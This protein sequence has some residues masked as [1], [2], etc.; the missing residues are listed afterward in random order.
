MIQKILLFSQPS[1]WLFL[2]SWFQRTEWQWQQDR[3]L[4]WRMSQ[5]LK[6]NQNYFFK[7]LWILPQSDKQSRSSS[8]MNE[9]PEQS[10]WHQS[11]PPVISPGILPPR[12][13]LCCQMILLHGRGWWDLWC[14]WC[15]TKIYFKEHWEWTK[16]PGSSWCILACIL[17]PPHWDCTLLTHS[18][19]V[20]DHHNYASR[21]CYS[22]SK[23]TLTWGH[24][25]QACSR[26]WGFWQNINIAIIKFIKSY[27]LN[28][29]FWM[30][31]LW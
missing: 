23:C 20:E 2:F 21:S 29:G 3:D 11:S 16:R 5:S 24:H 19:R 28:P 9:S 26:D 18:C 12:P 8:R 30:S 4:S 1:S 27:S 31:F 14:T 15:S 13:G 25:H 22:W 10:T 7:N 6:V 17:P